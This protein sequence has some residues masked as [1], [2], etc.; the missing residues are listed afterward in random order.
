MANLFL[1]TLPHGRGS[2]LYI[3]MPLAL[4]DILTSQFAD[5]QSINNLD[6]E[7]Q[8]YLS[9]SSHLTRL[10]NSRQG[11]LQH[12]PD[13]G[14]PDITEIYQGLPYSVNQLTQAIKNTIEKYEPRLRNVY[15]SQNSDAN[16]DYIL[17]LLIRGEIN[18]GKK[19]EFDTYFVNE[20]TAQI[21]FV[22]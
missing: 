4:F 7:Q 3:H 10:L 22:K 20:G 17:H 8:T 2:E 6:P 9:I 16:K 12:L 5:G 19:L 1:I 18:G 21:N 14:L 13:Y 15:V 11:S